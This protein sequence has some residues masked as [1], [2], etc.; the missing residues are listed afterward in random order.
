[1]NRLFL[2]F[3]FFVCVGSVSAEWE[4]YDDVSVVI[5]NNLGV[6]N[7]VVPRFNELSKEGS[8]DILVTGK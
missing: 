4:I 6:T 2:I 5:S 1:M 7:L 8:I 3:A